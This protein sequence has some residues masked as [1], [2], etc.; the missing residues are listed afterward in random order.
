[1]SRY[2]RAELPQYIRKLAYLSESR[3]GSYDKGRGSKRSTRTTR[4][5]IQYRRRSGEVWGATRIN[6]ANRE[7]LILTETV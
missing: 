1:M 6:C 3:Y 5:K 2:N 4:S 7:G